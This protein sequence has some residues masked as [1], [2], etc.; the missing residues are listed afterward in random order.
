MQRRQP[1]RTYRGAARQRA[2]ESGALPTGP[3]AYELCRLRSWMSLV[4]YCS[5]LQR[6][7]HG[8]ACLRRVPEDKTA[9]AH[10]DA[11]LAID[12]FLSKALFDAA[13]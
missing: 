3:N 11:N 2:R 8:T 7:L 13:V 12:D 10:G 9:V 5:A 6:V 4:L 1:R